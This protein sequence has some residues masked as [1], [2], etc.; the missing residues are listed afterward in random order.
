MA[1]NDKVTVYLKS[2]KT[3]KLKGTFSTYENGNEL[4]KFEFKTVDKK[5]LYLNLDS[6]D[7]II[8]EL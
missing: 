3:I 7:A 2:G 5:V 1:K 4:I 6:I 8:E